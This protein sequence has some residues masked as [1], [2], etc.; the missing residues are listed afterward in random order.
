VQLLLVLFGLVLEVVVL[1]RS[2]QP[3]H[4][5]NSTNTSRLGAFR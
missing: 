5:S 3:A 2:S 1:N 4:G